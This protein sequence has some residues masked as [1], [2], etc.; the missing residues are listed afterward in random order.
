[1]NAPVGKTVTMPFVLWGKVI[2]EAVDKGYPSYSSYL[3][4]IIKQRNK[5]TLKPHQTQLPY[6]CI[7]CGKIKG[8]CKCKSGFETGL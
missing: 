2:S 4:E 3:R 5:L 7:K 8:D 1:M 6:T